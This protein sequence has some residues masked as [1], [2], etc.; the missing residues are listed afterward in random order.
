MAGEGAGAVLMT[1]SCVG[2]GVD[3]AS[4]PAVLAADALL[5][6]LIVFFVGGAES[7]EGAAPPPPPPD[8]PP[9]TGDGD[10]AGRD[11]EPPV[12]PCL[13]AAPASCAAAA[14]AAP[15]P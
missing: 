9:G 3:A 12:V 6:S 10:V 5:L 4:P 13:A 14:I 2:K 15:V 1:T 11:A 7:E 8:A